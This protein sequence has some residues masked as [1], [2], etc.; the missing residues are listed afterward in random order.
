M[1][2]RPHVL[3]SKTHDIQLYEVLSL[4]L[5]CNKLSYFCNLYYIIITVLFFISQYLK[6]KTHTT[7]AD[8]G[9]FI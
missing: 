7:E 5:Q 8:I 4:L 2:S 3:I 9:K 6:P 1:E